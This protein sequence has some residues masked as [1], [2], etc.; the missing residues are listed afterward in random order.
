MPA[1][2]EI[3][4]MQ[5]QN[6]NSVL[7]HNDELAAIFDP[8]GCAEDWLKLLDERKLKL[9]S[10]YCTHGHYDHI[11]AI[12]ELPKVPW[13]V[14]PDEIEMINWSNQILNTMNMPQIDLINN[15]PQVLQMGK[16]EILPKVFADT[17]HCPGHSPGCVAYYFKPEKTLLIGDTLFQETVGAYHFP[18]GN[19]Q[20][21]K[22]SI[23]KIYNMNLSDDTIVIHGHGMH[24][25]IG[26]LKENNPF[27]TNNL[28]E[29]K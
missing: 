21:L 6:T 2:I 23:A 9:Y 17:I 14:H 4:F 26:W 24:T 11:S 25:T 13:F 18:G 22:E 7:V 19:E 15:P 1:K 5:P 16:N 27:F 8:W 12:A 20:Q 28:K 10:I 29:K 3:I